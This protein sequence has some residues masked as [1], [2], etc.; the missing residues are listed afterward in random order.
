[1][2]VSRKHLESND[3]LAGHRSTCNLAAM[4]EGQISNEEFCLVVIQMARSSS[5]R[6]R[7]YAKN[8]AD[9]YDDAIRHLSPDV[10][11]NRHVMGRFKQMIRTVNN[12]IQISWNAAVKDRSHKSSSKS[13]RN[14]NYRDSDSFSYY[15]YDSY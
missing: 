2:S 1:M 5:Q 11:V 8:Y 12:E 15:S 13:Y 3:G 7:R 4:Y 6:S 14:C 9:L 10:K